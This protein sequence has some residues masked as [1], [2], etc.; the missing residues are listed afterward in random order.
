MAIATMSSE[1]RNGIRHPHAVN[2]SVPTAS[3]VRMMTTRDRTIPS[4]GEVCSQPV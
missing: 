1:S 3:R 4:V 2:A